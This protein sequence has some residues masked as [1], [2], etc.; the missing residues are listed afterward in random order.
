MIGI[1]KF[2]NGE[3]AFGF[4]IEKETGNEYFV[5]RSGLLED[6]QKGNEVAF[7]L[8]ESKKEIRGEKPMIAVNVYITKKE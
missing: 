3:K 6:I 2:Y 8:K 5:H 1:V 7:E 4:I